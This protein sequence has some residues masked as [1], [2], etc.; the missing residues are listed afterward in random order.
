MDVF[1]PE[2]GCFLVSEVQPSFAKAKRLPKVAASFARRL[3]LNRSETN[4]DCQLR[5]V[6]QADIAILQGH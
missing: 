5:R 2:G 3:A 1:Y 6:D 4:Y